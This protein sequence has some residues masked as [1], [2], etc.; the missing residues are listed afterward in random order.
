MKIAVA[1][2]DKSNVTSH[3]GRCQKFWVY[4]V[5]SRQVLGK[6]LLELHYFSGTK[7]N[8]LQVNISF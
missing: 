2:Q 7:E 8:F 3:A 4:E 5:D 1:S 6:E